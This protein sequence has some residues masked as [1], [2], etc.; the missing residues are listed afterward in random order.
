MRIR[1]NWVFKAFSGVSLVVLPLILTSYTLS[2]SSC[3]SASDDT[4][5]WSD[6]F[7]GSSIDAG[8]WI[9]DIGTGAEK[10]LVGWGN[11]ELQ[12][13][14]N[15][16]ENARIE[17]FGD[18]NKGLVIEARKESYQGSAYTSARLLTQG[19]QSWTYGRIEARIKLPKGQGIWPA[20]WMLGDNITELAW[21]L[22]GE[23]DIM[24]YKGQEPGNVHG[25][26]HYGAPAH[27][28]QGGQSKDRISGIDFSSDFHVFGIRWSSKEIQWYVDDTV[29]HIEND[30]E[31]SDGMPAPFDKPFHILLNVAVGGN[32]IGSPDASTVF[33]QKMYVDWVRV[34]N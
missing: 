24:E 26:I 10:G 29:Y 4:L 2:L 25:T 28:Y 6:E 22:C 8:N 7:N 32:F 1:K 11:N 30:W 20:F 31:S 13:Y 17:D 9:Y 15:R 18:G 3:K 23:I 14:T 27:R 19:K 33:P 16:S 21:P 34:Y 5:V 12:Y